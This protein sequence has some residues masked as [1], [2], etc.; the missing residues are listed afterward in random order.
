MS[1]ETRS[2]DSERKLLAVAAAQ[3]RQAGSGQRAGAGVPTE[4]SERFGETLRR[5]VQI[6][7]RDK[8]RLAVVLILTLI[9]VILTVLGP[10]LL[11]RATDTIVAGFTGG[12]VDFA[13][14]NEQLLIVV[15]VYVVAG[16][17]T[18][19]QGFLLAGVVQRSMYTLREAVA[20]KL[21]RVSIRHVDRQARGDLLSRVNND[22]DNLAQSFQQTISTALTVILTLLGVTVMM[23]VISPLMAVVALITLPVSL[24][25]MKWMSKL[26]RP[27]FLDQWRLTGE[28]NARAEETFTGHEVVKTF[29]REHVVEE[30]FREENDELYE[31]GFRAQFTSGLIGPVVMFMGNVQYLLV[32]VV[33]GLQIANGSLSVGEMQAFIQYARQFSGPLGAFAA[34]VA[35]FQSGMAS[36]ERVLEVLDA[37]EQSTDPPP[38]FDSEPAPERRALG[39]VVFDDVSFAYDP[40]TP[41]IEGLSVTA[42][43]GQTIAIV[44]PT[45]AGKTTLVNLI[46]RFYE[47]DGGTIS[48]DGQDIASMPRHEL[49]SQLGMVL[50]DTWLFGGTIREN[51]AYGNPEAT[52]EQILEAAKATFV[53][54]FVRSLPDG[55]DTLIDD[56]GDNLSAGEMQLITIARAFLSEPTILILDEATSSVDTRTEVMIQAAMSALRSRRTSFV[57]AHRLSTIRGADIIVVMEHGR[58]VEQGNHETLLAADGPYARL[59]EAQFAGEAT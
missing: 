1:R 6:V 47:V 9:S 45:G 52:D 15:A 36:L 44:G 8:I 24:W 39:R 16:L 26:A 46:M 29:G 21:D 37:D 57:I 4:R 50:Q 35:T 33:G 19:A 23:F 51:I 49:R 18:Y 30:L 10:R 56:D 25:L 58:I 43:P 53:D 40:D 59:H 54:R 27:R 7:G 22:I 17:L 41:L 48:I 31:A 38:R 28:L 14:L 12:G 32:A 5:L 42:E 55:Y 3:A 13:K 34:V 20:A 11:G 2:T